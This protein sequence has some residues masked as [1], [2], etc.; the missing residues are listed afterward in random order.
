MPKTAK[1]KLLGRTKKKKASQVIEKPPPPPR[2]EPESAVSPA[3]SLMAQQERLSNSSGVGKKD[4]DLSQASG[5]IAD[6]SDSEQGV[7]DSRKEEV[8]CPKDDFDAIR[9]MILHNLTFPAA[10]RKMGWTGK[11]LVKF[12]IKTD[13]NVADIAIL[14]SSGH[15][16][17]DANLIRAIRKTSPFPKPTR[18]A[19]LL[20]PIAYKLQ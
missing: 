16:L 14:S 2:S 6:R 15:A 11:I 13:G 3:L 10:A 9:K 19:Q 20:L 7:A 12:T 4:R 18:Q 1:P 8:G 17:L 5:Q